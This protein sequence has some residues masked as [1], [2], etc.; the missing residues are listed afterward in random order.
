MNH[1]KCNINFQTQYAYIDNNISS[2]KYIHISE[3]IQHKNKYIGVCNFYCRN[4]HELVFVNGKKNKP[5]FR[6]KNTNDLDFSNPMTE[7]HC[8]WQ[9]N[10][11]ITE[12]EFKKICEKQIKNRR[13]DILLDD[14]NIIEIQHSLITKD[15]VEN[16][17]NDYKFHNK[18]IIW[19]IDGN[20]GIIITELTYSKRIYLEFVSQNWKFESFINCDYIY[21]NI[22]DKIYKVYPK[23]IKSNMSD[24]QF[25]VT[26]EYFI[27]CLQNGRQIFENNEPVQCKLFIKQ[28]GAGNGKTYGIIKMLECD[29]F[30]HY[31]SFIY[32]SKQHSAVHVIYNEF[33][34]QIR[35]G[36][37]TYLQLDDEPKLIN[38]KYVIKYTNL[39]SNQIC[40]III[41]TVD[42]FMYAIGNKNHNELNMFEGIINSIIDDHIETITSCGTIKYAS[43]N[44]KLCK[45]SIIIKDEEQD[46]TIPYAKAIIQIMRNRYIDVYI[47]G[48]KLQSISHENNAFTY[49][50]TNDFPYIEKTVYEFT[51]ICRRFNHPK[52]INFVNNMIPF[53]KYNLPEIEGP[54]NKSKSVV[55]FNKY[56]NIKYDNEEPIVIFE[57]ESIYNQRNENKINR[58]IEIIMNY[59]E[60]EVNKFHRNPNDFLIVTP[61]TQSNPLVDALQLTIN[62]FWKEKYDNDDEYKRYAVFH[63]SEQGNSINLN[64]SN[65][66]TRIVSIHS[67]KGDGRPVVFVIGINE[68]ALIRFSESCDSLIFNSLFHVALTR[69]KEKLYIRYENNGDYISNKIQQWLHKTGFDINIKP[70]I[71]IYNKIKYKDIIESPNSRN[72]YTKINETIFNQL[73]LTKIG[74]DENDKK[75]IDTSHHNIRYASILINLY[76]QI[77]RNQKGTNTK[78]QIT[79]IFNG[80]INIGITE[81]NNWKSYNINLKEKFIPILKISD[82]GRDYKKYFE[83]IVCF[84]N[85]ILSKLK[86]II[87]GEYLPS[88]CPMESIILFYMIQTSNNGEYTTIHISELY[89]I[90]DIYNKTYK[91]DKLLHTNC[92]CNESFIN[93][94]EGKCL[95]GSY[96]LEK[97]IF[98]HFEKMAIITKQYDNF[99]KDYKN[100]NWLIDHTIDFNGLTDDFRIYQRFE[101]IGYNDEYVFI[102]YVKP[103]FNQ[104]NY[105]RTLIQS[106]YDSFIVKNIKKPNEDDIDSKNKEYIRNNYARFNNK[107]I[108]CL[109]FSTDLDDPYY[110]LWKD[111]NNKNI[112][113]E[114]TNVILDI[115]YNDVVSKYNI[116]NKMIYNFYKY[117]RKNC[118]EKTPLDIITFIISQLNGIKQKQAT[119]IS[120]ELPIFV[121]EF[122]NNIKFRI[123]NISNKRDQINILKEYDNKDTFLTMLNERMVPFIRRF[124]GF[125]SKKQ[126]IEELN[127]D[128]IELSF[129]DD[130]ESYDNN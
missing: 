118:N 52:L 124:F 29:D 59:Y 73:Q 112:F 28:Q 12:V 25:P 69:M 30:L 80:I 26:K 15:E 72:N 64:E 46:L 4:Q 44:P 71:I 87:K 111:N 45:N 54:Q 125:E 83:I 92:L 113:N 86:K 96:E 42:S 77:I 68:T 21:I 66:A 63:K 9:S 61:F 62:I 5:H 126:P 24:I 7:W 107:E 20:E 6:H 110:I 1:T 82:K 94:N 104:L 129:S 114:N 90:I 43:I 93:E 14:N 41:G 120:G 39:K 121:N 40:N 49:L 35:L 78:K 27:D 51:N 103:Q 18:N 101:L 88:L 76:Q 91:K 37:L 65:D 99:N 130:D 115:I 67:S 122:F 95:N 36:N 58:E 56:N 57:G 2:N 97:Y 11:P 17:I 33:K 60:D 128:D 79:A 106:A 105:N 23:L 98:T 34:N 81:A 10:F 84:S 13:A 89:N 31:N 109:V 117:W 8:E 19:V 50:L 74:N 55:S 102:V 123:E 16:R 53:N 32:L 47:V 48:D 100:V 75:I 127:E 85:N 38:K 116:E 119:I 3:C 22:A 108:I 70:N